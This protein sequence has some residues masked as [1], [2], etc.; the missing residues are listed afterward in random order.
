MVIIG[1]RE[2]EEITQAVTANAARFRTPCASN[3]DGDN[4]DTRSGVARRAH[5]HAHAR[6]FIACRHRV[7]PTPN[8]TAGPYKTIAPGHQ[9]E[10]AKVD[11]QAGGV[12]G[13]THQYLLDTVPCLPFMLTCLFFCNLILLWFFFFFSFFRR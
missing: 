10:R 7:V 11:W 8:A 2:L 4:V 3:D 12:G 13:S 5:A 9:P 6:G 1:N